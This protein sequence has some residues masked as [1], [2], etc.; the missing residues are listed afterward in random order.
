MLRLLLSKFCIIY[1]R[2][3]LPGEPVPGTGDDVKKLRQRVDEVNHL[4][5]EEQQ[6]RFAEVSQDANHSEGHPGKVAER[7]SHKHR[8][9]VP[10]KKKGQFI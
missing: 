5:N 2:N 6:H 8:R 7:V 10:V 3:E 4:R 1:R 9:G